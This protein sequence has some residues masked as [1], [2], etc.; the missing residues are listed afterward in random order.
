[1]GIG[2]VGGLECGEGIHVRQN[3]PK[4]GFSEISKRWANKKAMQPISAN[5]QEMRKALFLTKIS[6]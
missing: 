1:M 3:N 5:L 2:N 6:I 4:A